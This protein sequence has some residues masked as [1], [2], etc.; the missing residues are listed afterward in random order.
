LFDSCDPSETEQHVITALGKHELTV[1]PATGSFHAVGNLATVANSKIAY[2]QYDVPIR[3]R[4]RVRRSYLFLAILEGHARVRVDDEELELACGQA[5]IIGPNRTLGLDTLDHASALVW[6]V[7]H[8]TLEHEAELLTGGEVSEP[9]R[10]DAHVQL[11]AGKGP[12]LL[13]AIRFVTAEMQDINGVAHS[14]PVQ[15]I[16]EQMLLRALLDAQ[17]SQLSDALK[18]RNSG[19]APRCVLRV[20]RYISGHLEEEIKVADLIKASG[21]SGRTM[22]SAF[23]KC[24]GVSPMAYLRNLRMQQVRRDLMRSEPAMRVTEILMR[25]GITQFGRFAAAY[26]KAYG[27]YPSE[28]LKR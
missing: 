8:D 9:V 21:V 13:R 6:K 19:E 18:C 24:R 4:A 15:D 23:R 27:E 26:K 2:L 16:L 11:D 17:P 12:S 28:T 10:F 1:L 22:F 14:R 5:A 25:R 3:L 20:E 7:A